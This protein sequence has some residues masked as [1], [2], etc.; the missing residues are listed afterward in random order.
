MVISSSSVVNNAVLNQGLF[1][2][3]VIHEWANWCQYF[4]N[5]NVVEARQTKG[6][7]LQPYLQTHRSDE[8]ESRA[9]CILIAICCKHRQRVLRLTTPCVYIQRID[10][11]GGNSRSK[12]ATVEETILRA[13]F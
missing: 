4:G 8:I 6:E 3:L 2:I 12:S 1:R 9:I 7:G 10:E 5:G 11:E 13:Y